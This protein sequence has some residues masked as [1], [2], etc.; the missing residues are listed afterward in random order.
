MSGL[1]R[2]DSFEGRNKFTT[3]A[4]K[5][6]ILNAGVELRKAVW[7]DLEFQLHDLSDPVQPEHPSPEAHPR[8]GRSLGAPNL[9]LSKRTLHD[10][11]NEQTHLRSDPATGRQY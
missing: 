6:G 3:W 11:H 7:R 9:V 1:S 2:L 10:D 8:T 4:F 5:F